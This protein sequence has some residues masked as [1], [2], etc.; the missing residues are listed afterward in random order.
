MSLGATLKALILFFFLRRKIGP[1]DG[2]KILLSTAF[3]LLATGVMA[4][5]IYVWQFL[6][7][8]WMPS[9]LMKMAMSIIVLTGGACIGLLIFFLMAKVFRMEE[10]RLIMDTARRKKVTDS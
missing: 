4:A 5:G 9:G 10:F 2:R 3:T 7:P 8:Y 6:L 1:M